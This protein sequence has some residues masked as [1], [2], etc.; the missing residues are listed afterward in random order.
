MNNPPSE[1]HLAQYKNRLV[2]YLAATRPQFLIASV[3][4]VM[5]GLAC[6]Y[7]ETGGLRVGLALMILLGALIA[8]AAVNVLNDYYDALNGTDA[9]NIERLYPFTGG[10]RFVQNGLLT[11]GQTARFGVLL[12]LLAGVIGGGLTVASG[13][14]LVAIG[15]IGFIVGWGYSAPPLRLNSRGLGELAVGLGFGV[16]IPL[17]AD[18]AQRGEYAILPVLAGIPYGLLVTN[19]LFINQFPDRRADEQ[20]GKH[21]W[22]VRL[23]PR[24]ARWIY[25]VL[26]LGAYGLLGWM[27]ILA[28][29]PVTASLALIPG[30]LTIRASWQLFLYAE[31]PARLEPAIRLTILAAVMFGVLLAIGLVWP[32]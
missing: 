29:L 8:H 32:G 10:S 4:P 19:L 11:T 30:V 23:G 25:P 22:V 7:G 14:G 26:G 2:L 16:L 5:L 31:Q 13:Y 15:F 3:V 27:I 20:A 12:L 21:H 24:R 6:Y 28:W 18:Y 1:P 9:I 17:G